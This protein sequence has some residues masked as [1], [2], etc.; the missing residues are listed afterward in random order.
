MLQVGS[1]N[2]TFN[3]IRREAIRQGLSDILG[4]S[5]ATSVIINFNLDA[6]EDSPASFHNSL[7]SLFKVPGTEVLEKSIIKELYGLM[8][9]HFD[10]SGT[11]D[12]GTQMNFA[13][14]L[15]N[16]KATQ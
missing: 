2:A 1:K 7:Y 3:S 6:Y 15:Y 10:S 9:E 13:K 4:L 11:F 14:K 12:F 16:A 8:G 5:G